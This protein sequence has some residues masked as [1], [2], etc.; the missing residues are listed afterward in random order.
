MKDELNSYGIINEDG[1]R[2]IFVNEGQVTFEN[3]RPGYIDEWAKTEQGEAFSVPETFDSPDA[4]D[5]QDTEGGNSDID[6][7]STSSSASASSAASASAG[8]GLGA[9]AG[10]VAA[11]VVAA[12]VVVA[13]VLSA[14]SI[15]LSLVMANMHSLTFKV[16]MTGVDETSF[17]EPIFA[18]LT[19]EDTER[20]LEVRAD[21]VLLTFEDLEPG[22]EYRLTLKNKQKIFAEVTAF[23]S[24]DQEDK[25]YIVSRMEG[26]EVFVTVERADLKPNE[27]Y[28]LIAEDANGN[29]VFSKDGVDPFVEYTF[30]VDEPQD[31]YFYLKVNG[32]VYA[33]SQV[34][35]PVYD[36]ANGAWIW[37]DDRTAATVIFTDI[38]G[39]ESLTLDATVTRKTQEPTCEEDGLVEYT[40]KVTYQG[41]SYTDKKTVVLQAV[42]HEYEGVVNEDGTIT[43]TC[44]N[45]GDTYTD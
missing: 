24:T 20:E 17:A 5:E 34:L 40:A 7:S 1:A 9:V 39:G 31:L 22:R 19:S 13:V 15:N 27:Y 16:T 28:T 23:T 45:C 29:V 41:K 35:I 37:N 8:G 26:T 30:K 21:T 42:G 43:Y 12:V 2:Q 18:V 38:K 11:S 36:F 32:K 3:D 25:G 10:A 44:P 4:V 33:L 14:F 6:L